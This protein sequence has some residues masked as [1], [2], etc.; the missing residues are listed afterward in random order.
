L[1]ASY[2]KLRRFV[3]LRIYI[4]RS[5]HYADLQGLRFLLRRKKKQSPRLSTGA[6]NQFPVFSFLDISLITVF[7][8]SNESNA[9]NAAEVACS[10]LEKKEF[11]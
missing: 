9:A 11:I 10:H 8:S 5:D 7:S 1:S 6:S 2:G 4:D 3:T